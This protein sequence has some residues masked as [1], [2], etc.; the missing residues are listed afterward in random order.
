VAR[1]GTQRGIESND[2][3]TVKERFSPF[4][5]DGML[6]DL[7]LLMV[8]EIARVDAGLLAT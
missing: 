7:A 8:P 5:G 6:D 1:P 3:P 2:A 4:L